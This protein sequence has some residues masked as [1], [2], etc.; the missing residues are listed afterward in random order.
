MGRH[1]RWSTRRIRGKLMR[2]PRLLTVRQVLCTLPRVAPLR[3]LI[4]LSGGSRTV[5]GRGMRLRGSRNVDVRGGILKL[6]TGSFG[7]ARVFDPGAV[8]VAG[9]LIIEG[10][11]AVGPG[12]R[13]LIESGSRVTI[14][15]ATYFSGWNIIY[16]TV[17]VTVGERCAIGWQT[18]FLDNDL[19]ELRIEGN[20]GRQ[21]GEIVIG[22]RVWLGSRVTVLKGTT[23]GSGCVVA[24]GSVVSGNFS[25]EACLI[26]GTP[27]R[28]IREG[29]WWNHG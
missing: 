2:R 26:G 22:D 8:R 13:W 1:E 10:S 24:A 12:A 6:G 25:K 17:G 7:L 19:H 3:T 28:V 18:Q 9:Q 23:I 27:A 11:A 5:V 16:S 14:G 29:V 20:L 21:S 15:N 4:A